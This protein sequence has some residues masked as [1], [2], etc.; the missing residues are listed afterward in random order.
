MAQPALADHEPIV[1]D[2]T[3]LS[4]PVES[5]AE[6]PCSESLFC[7]KNLKRSCIEFKYYADAI[8]SG[9]TPPG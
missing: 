6:M 9:L 4:G 8:H 1:R 2:W 3:A 7:K 5:G